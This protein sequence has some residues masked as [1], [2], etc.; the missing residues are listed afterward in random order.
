MQ[1]LKAR[2]L[3][4]QLDSSLIEEL[5]KDGNGVCK[6]EFVIGMLIQ[7]EV[8]ARESARARMPWACV[9]ARAVCRVL[10]ALACAL[11][12]RYVCSRVYRACIARV[13]ATPLVVGGPHRPATRASCVYA[14]CPSYRVPPAAR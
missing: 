7:L 4:K 11:Y 12:V 3:A 14:L 13:G 2:R 6:L 9:F 10:R 1:L 8:R 5:D